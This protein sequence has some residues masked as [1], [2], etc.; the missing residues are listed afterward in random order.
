MFLLGRTGVCFPRVLLGALIFFFFHVSYPFIISV[1][2]FTTYFTPKLFCYFWLRL[3]VRHCTQSTNLLKCSFIILFNFL[4]CLYFWN[5]PGTFSVFFLLPG[6][7]DL[8]L[9]FCIVRLVCGYLSAVFFPL[10]HLFIT[11]VCCRSFFIHPSSFISHRWSRSVRWCFALGYVAIIYLLFRSLHWFFQSWCLWNDNL[12]FCS[13]MIF[14]SFSTFVL[15]FYFYIDMF[16]GSVVIWFS[17][18][19][20]LN[21]LGS[22]LE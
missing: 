5:G 6:T 7:F 19:C 18:F 11:F 10:F 12:V 21:H 17:I 3:L 20:V 4:F 14:I 2:L 9:A 16:L 13:L 22:S 8:F 15:S 1:L